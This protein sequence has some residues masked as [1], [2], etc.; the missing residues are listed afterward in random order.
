[1]KL[2]Q[3]SVKLLIGIVA[4]MLG[5]CDSCSLAY[6]RMLRNG[7]LEHWDTPWVDAN[8]NGIRDDVDD[9]IRDSFSASA[10][11]Q[12]AAE[13]YALAIQ[14]QLTTPI[15]SQT[16][17]KTQLYK[18]VNSMNCVFDVFPSGSADL[19]PAY[20]VTQIEALTINSRVRYEAVWSLSSRLSGSSWGIPDHNTCN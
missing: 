19:E 1:M 13:Q 17:V 5:G 2:K 12:R 15:Y 11:Y 6:F 4:A 8:T 16:D 14:A 10:K 7:D 18:V 9:L 3:L 20:V